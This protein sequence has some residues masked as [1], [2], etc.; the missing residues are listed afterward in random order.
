MGGLPI[1]YLNY[2]LFREEQIEKCRNASRSR[3]QVCMETESKLM[4]KYSEP[5]RTEAPV[6]LSLR[7][8]AYYSEAAI[9]LIE[10]LVLKDG[11]THVLDTQNRGAYPFLEDRDVV[12]V[13]CRVD[14]EGTTPLPYRAEVPR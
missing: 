13:Q 12:E 8:G 1:S 14:G 5:H 7:G 9:S 4:E 2:F 11:K 3:A 6:E 10:S